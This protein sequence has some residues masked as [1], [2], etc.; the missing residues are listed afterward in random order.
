MEEKYN[1]GNASI[2][3]SCENLER[4][5]EDIDKAVFGMGG[6]FRN[7]TE[8]REMVHDYMCLW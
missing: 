4:R 1:P 2:L 6:T 5:V 8:C 3:G 7:T